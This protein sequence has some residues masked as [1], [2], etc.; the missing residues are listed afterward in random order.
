[1]QVAAR[2]YLAAGVALVSAGAIAVS[3]V[4]PPVPEAL[5]KSPAVQLSAAI[6]PITPWV[7]VFNTAGVNFA[8]LVESWLEAPA[9][10]LQQVIANQIRY[11]GELPDVPAIV[12][13]IAANAQAA[14][15]APFAE[16]LSTLTPDHANVYELLLNGIPPIIEPVVSPNLAPLVRFSTTYLSGVLL[17]L[18]GPMINPTLALGGSLHSVIE[19][20]TSATPDLEAA[21]NTLLN[22]PAAMANSF[23]NGGQSV[24]VTQLL[25]AVG[26]NS[27]LPGAEFSAQLVFGGLLSPGGSIFNA[28]TIDL[29]DGSGPIGIGP[30]AIGSLIGLTKAIAQAIGWDGTGWPLAPPAADEPQPA[31]S[32]ATSTAVTETPSGTATLVSLDLTGESATA[33]LPAGSVTDTE[34]VAGDPDTTTATG[35]SED[36]EVADDAVEDTGTST[37]TD[38]KEAPGGAASTRPD[39]K[40]LNDVRKGVKGAGKNDNDKRE[41]RGGKDESEEKPAKAGGAKDSTDS[42]TSG[43]KSESA[44]DGRSS[45]SGSGSE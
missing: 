15:K 26:I 25:K 27:P 44:S 39:S 22:I 38:G 13:Q 16:D 34:V 12:G 31:L 41:D 4:A 6:D 17:G 1:M 11:L 3:P 33:E 32:A 18:V 5:A 14:I 28:M 29:G 37:G 20:L 45:D 43:G 8:E 19:N 42:A 2:N 10:V 40:P 9:P 36:D 30:G 23:L 7:N 35:T 21:F 24:D